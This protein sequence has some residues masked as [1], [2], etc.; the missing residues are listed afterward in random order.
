[1]DEI[2]IVGDVGTVRV[3]SFG[4]TSSNICRAARICVDKKWDGK[5][6]DETREYLLKLLK[7]GHLSPFEFASITFEVE[8]PIFVK[9]QLVRY[10]TASFMERS[11]R[12][13][14]AEPSGDELKRVAFAFPPD[15]VDTVDSAIKGAFQTY[16]KLVDAGVRREDARQVL[17]LS[18]RTRYLMGFK[19]R[20]LFHVFDERLTN[21][22]QRETRETVAAMKEL[23]AF[24]FPEVVSAYDE[25]NESGRPQTI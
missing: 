2:K 17:P 16:R 8:T 4:G 13:C 5:T 19:L 10:R 22:A 7:R 3:F 9:N 18:T 21:G 15:C 25:W 1:M 24:R 14:K 12:Y 6:S 23:A 11:L 20:N